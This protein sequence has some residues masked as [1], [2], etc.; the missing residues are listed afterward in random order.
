MPIAITSVQRTEIDE[1]GW[2]ILPGVISGTQLEAVSMVFD[3]VAVSGAAGTSF[4]DG[5]W[6][7]EAYMFWFTPPQERKR[8][9]DGLPGEVSC[10][11][12][13]GLSR[14]EA[15][16]DLVDHEH[17]LSLVV[18]VAGWNIQVSPRQLGACRFPASL[19]D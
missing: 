5:I 13:N 4:P 10:T 8:A 12:R 7:P 2:T 1:I 19:T 3:E 18:D 15:L 6:P 14:H 17:V 9:E 16:L 11:W